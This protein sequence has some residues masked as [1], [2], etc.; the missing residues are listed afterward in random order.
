MNL[1]ERFWR[2]ALEV[3]PRMFGGLQIQD[4]LIAGE[5]NVSI[6]PK[7]STRSSTTDTNASGIVGIDM[8]EIKPDF[9]LEWLDALYNLAA[10]NGD[11][12]YAVE[13]I[14]G[15]GNTNHTVSFDDTIPE[16]LAAEMSAHLK[17]VEDSWYAYGGGMYSL[18]NDLFA[19]AAIAGC[20]SAEIIPKEDI[21]GVKSIVKVKPSSIRFIYDREKGRYLAGQKVPIGTAGAD[22]NGIKLLNETTYKYVA[23]RRYT[24]S[25]YG[26]PPFLSAVEPLITQRNMLDNFNHIMKKMG[27]LGFISVLMNMPTRKQGETQ[28]A[29]NTRAENHLKASV[30]EIDKSIAKGF[31]LG[32]K[33]SHEIK[34]NGVD[35][36][37]SG[38][39]E[40]YNLNEQNVMTGLKQDPAMLGRSF[41]TT[42]T[43]G[44][45]ILA[46][47]GS[48][49][50]NY[51]QIVATFIESAYLLELMMAGY[52]PKYVKVV[53]DK[54]MLSDKSK[55]EEG[56]AKKIANLRA[57]WADGIISQQE[58]AKEMGYEEPAELI[59]LNEEI[60][61]TPEKKENEPSKNAPDN[62]GGDETNVDEGTTSAGRRE[63]RSLSLRLGKGVAEYPYMFSK[64]PVNMELD[65]NDGYLDPKLERKLRLY[66]AQSAATYRRATTKSTSEIAT[67]LLG[68]SAN[69][70]QEQ[71]LDKV[72]FTLYKNW[73]R[74]FTAKE[75]AVINKYVGAIYKQFRKDKSIFDGSGGKTPDAIFEVSDAR[76]IKHFE[77]SDSFYLGKF[78]TDESTVKKITKYIKEAYIAG[79]TPIG[80]DRKNLDKF[81]RRFKG[82]LNGEDHKITRVISTTVNKMRNYA[83]IS[84]MEQAGVD[85]F[86]VVGVSDNLQCDWCKGVQGKQFKVSK[87][88]TTINAEVQASV[89]SVG[90]LKPFLVSGVKSDQVANLTGADLQAL[91][92]DAPPYHPS[93]RDVV[94]ALFKNR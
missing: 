86:E 44:R 94:I 78:I 16:K 87:A 30:P 73:D 70:T 38:A 13:N 80:N 89:D 23:L 33:G 66:T 20:I 19:Q 93:C 26:I 92:F 79:D 58:Y 84:Y 75:K 28:E 36:Q 54:P 10:Y 88:M 34:L 63:V 90:E 91:G 18:K 35:S 81:K 67:V 56:K 32:Y 46:K 68:M 53:F 40:M 39:T 21:S 9:M 64:Y 50:T 27:M 71:V 22:V 61:D 24:E 83:A 3:A 45:V 82:T 85:T 48:Q 6:P 1:R 7:G 72:L 41:T 43:F 76:T 12:S 77:K 59:D 11:V 5:D 51:Q 55:E 49:V 31:V 65:A 14:I 47:L 15:L 42:E 69:A 57:L 29:Y 74:N 2:T 17:R 60:E 37:S 4:E 62:T 52:S 25:P 8:N